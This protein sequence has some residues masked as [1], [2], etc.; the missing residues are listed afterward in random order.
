MNTLKINVLINLLCDNF[1]CEYTNILIITRSAG[2]VMSDQSA[3][4]VFQLWHEIVCLV[5]KLNT[6]P[7]MQ[8]CKIKG[9]SFISSHWRHVIKNKRLVFDIPIKSV[10]MYIPLYHSFC[11]T[12][13]TAYSYNMC[14][15]AHV[16]SSVCPL[17]LHKGTAWTHSM[18]Q[19][20]LQQG[21]YFYFAS[22][23]VH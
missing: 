18:K 15:Q 19:H 1:T 16:R 2:N 5:L 7:I 22:V 4:S 10:N 23:F 11:W 9:I 12:E 6:P 21:V 14:T 13:Y 3:Y 20:K 8:L 17:I